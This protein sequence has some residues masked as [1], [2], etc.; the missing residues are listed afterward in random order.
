MNRNTLYKHLDGIR[1]K[2]AGLSRSVGLEAAVTGKPD[3]DRRLS[4]R[5]RKFVPGLTTIGS[6][7]Q[8]KVVKMGKHFQPKFTTFGGLTGAGTYTTMYHEMVSIQ[9]FGLVSGIWQKS[10]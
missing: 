6:W 2:P 10:K 3:L 9:V 4:M 8:T 7:I 5:I 1:G